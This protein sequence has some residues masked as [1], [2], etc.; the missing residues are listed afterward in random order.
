MFCTPVSG[1]RVTTQAAVKKGA[2]SKPGVEIGTGSD[3]RPWPGPCS[4]AP[5][6]TISWQGG[7]VTSTGGMG[8]AI[9]R[10]QAGPMASSVGAFMPMR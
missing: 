4:A 5:S 10:S 9:A 8:W 7:L 3:S 6:S 2:A 1:S